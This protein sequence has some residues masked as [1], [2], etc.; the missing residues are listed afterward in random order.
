MQSAVVELPVPGGRRQNAGAFRR[1]QLACAQEEVGVQVGVR[2]ERQLQTAPTRGL[3]RVPQVQAHV[4]HQRSPVSEVD[5]VGGIA[6]PFID[7]RN[8]S[9]V[10]IAVPLLSTGVPSSS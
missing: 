7:E 8:T 2:G 5:Q 1:G 10:P 3:P 9:T 4:Q 6:E